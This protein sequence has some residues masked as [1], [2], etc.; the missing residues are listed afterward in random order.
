M[1]GR[2]DNFAVNYAFPYATD[3]P[4][5]LPAEAQRVT[6]GFTLIELSIA[7]VIIG[8]IVGG[9]LVGK[10]LI[11]A[12]EIRATIGQIEEY[13]AAV[14]TFSTKFDCLPGDCIEAS[15]FGFDA[16]SNGNGDGVIGECSVSPSCTWNV[17]TDNAL[18]KET[19]N[20]WYH[21]SVAGLIPDH[22]I[23][24]SSGG[25]GIPGTATPKVKINSRGAGTAGWTIQADAP[26]DATLGSGY[27]PGHVL[28]MSNVSSEASTGS[29]ALYTPADIN[30]IDT[31]MDDGLPLSG[32]VRAYI[33]IQTAFLSGG[34]YK[35]NTLF[36]S[37]IGAGGANSANC[38]RNDKTPNQY[39]VPYTG[40]TLT[41]LCGVVIKAAF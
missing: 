9:I 32:S 19:V 24:P 12:A 30:A 14:N 16:V 29:T 7:L 4:C 3:T 17:S 8:L 2:T 28:T 20:F 34:D 15:A 37:G 1:I 26:F 38:I 21:L 41:G 6:Q 36:G 40:S 23:T 27:L 11:H 31:K 10:D 13:N 22:L 33:W 18:E 5:D 39:N 35:F 25:S